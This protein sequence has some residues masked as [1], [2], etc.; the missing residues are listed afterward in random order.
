MLN[1]SPLST[2]VNFFQFLIRSSSLLKKPW[3]WLILMIHFGHESVGAF[4]RDDFGIR[5]DCFPTC[6]LRRGCRRSILCGR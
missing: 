6:L 5:A 2:N 1:K 4:M 3:L